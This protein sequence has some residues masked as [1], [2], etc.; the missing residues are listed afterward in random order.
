GISHRLASSR[1][2]RGHVRDG[3]EPAH[4][5]HPPR[6]EGGHRLAGGYMSV[7]DAIRMS[8]ST[9]MLVGRVAMTSG[10]VMPFL[11]IGAGQ[12]RVDKDMQP[13]LPK[14][15]E[16]AALVGAGFE[17]GIAQKLAVAV[18]TDWTILYRETRE[19]TNIDT[20]HIFSAFAALRLEL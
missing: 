15:S 20:A 11:Q 10:M 18:E 12:W 5:A 14:D 7:T 2:R 13:Y 8:R 19:A 16:L 17:I 9:R 4:G 3:Y 1:N 6:L